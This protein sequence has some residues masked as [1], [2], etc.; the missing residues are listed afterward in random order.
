MK[1]LIADDQMSVHR[2][3]N[4]CLDHMALGINHILHA[5]DGKE[6][7]ELIE[8]EKPEICILD[9]EMPVMDG[10]SVLRE[11]PEGLD[12]KV[13]ILSA[14]DQF[15]YARQCVGYGVVDYLLKPIDMDSFAQKMRHILAQL[16]EE[17]RSRLLTEF[18]SLA[19]GAEYTEEKAAVSAELF[20]K[21]QIRYY[22][23]SCTYAA[24][25]FSPAGPEV[26]LF[27]TIFR[28][29]RYDFFSVGEPPAWEKLCR[30]AAA[31]EGA[32][33]GYSLLQQAAE[34]FGDGIV[35][36]Q[37]AL[38]QSFYKEGARLYQ[39]E[40]FSRLQAEDRA[41][42]LRQTLDGI[43]LGNMELAAKTV[44]SVFAG[45]AGKRIR[46]DDVYGFCYAV[47]AYL[48]RE[49]G[50]V[51]EEDFHP[52]SPLLLE[53]GCQLLKARFFN[54]IKARLLQIQTTVSKTDTEIVQEIKAY[55][56]THYDADLS[57]ED[58]SASFFMSKYQVS[59]LFKKLYG[60]NYQDYLLQTRM[61][62]AKL[63]LQNTS[64]KL[65]E[66]AQKTGFKEASYFSLVFKKCYGMS[67]H[68]FRMQK[69]ESEIE[70]ENHFGR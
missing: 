37:E 2:F 56:D 43:R 58:V 14:Y 55:V 51:P 36:A 69:T 59:R 60:T 4:R 1:L 57:L 40:Y 45:F 31:A 33:A 67:P 28:Q 12:T 24:A 5:S 9:I 22:G 50:S 66:I 27:H 53:N 44:E 19:A 46:P 68:E 7:L 49:I 39:K 26:P 61:E 54:A 70:K 48:E 32:A 20:H 21:L 23:V 52:P 42:I 3:F 25:P 64:L 62:K 6:A 38:G 47:L 18:H 13:L 41:E 63:L 16:R 11:M 8:R 34:Q 65:Y 35:Q 30:D 29:L 10:I 17:Y 15:E